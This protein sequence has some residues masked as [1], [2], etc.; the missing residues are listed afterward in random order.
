MAV[1][2]APFLLLRRETGELSAK[3][4]EGA[5]VSRTSVGPTPP[6]SRGYAAR[7]LPRFA[8]EDTI[9]DAQGLLRT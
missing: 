6:P 5:S 8:V 1:G 2:A 7:H 9:L 3:P 4:T